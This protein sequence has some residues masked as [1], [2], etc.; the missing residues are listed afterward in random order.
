MVH[1]IIPI[2][3][4]LIESIMKSNADYETAAT[5]DQT[6]ARTKGEHTYY[7]TGSITIASSAKPCFG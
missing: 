5:F 6:L 3:P 7:A 1:G 4:A 2:P